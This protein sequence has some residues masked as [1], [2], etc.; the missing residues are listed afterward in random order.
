MRPEPDLLRQRR[1]MRTALVLSLV[2]HALLLSL[3]FGGQG[4]GLPG[5]ELP[6]REKRLEADDLHVILMPAQV[7]PAP[8]AVP[9][10]PAWIAP[11]TDPEPKTVT[12]TQTAIAVA[13]KAEI[14]PPVA[15]KPAAVAPPPPPPPSP[16]P[17]VMAVDRSDTATLAVPPAPLQ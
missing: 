11:L 16:A 17:E 3:G 8:A 14:A 6:W 12:P 7:A 2:I 1:R 5:L 9:A 10:P 4:F 13:A 15:E